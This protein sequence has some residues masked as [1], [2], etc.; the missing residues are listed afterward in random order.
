MVTCS[1]LLVYSISISQSV[2]GLKHLGE[3]AKVT[4]LCESLKQALNLG[5]PGNLTSVPVGLKDWLYV[6]E[7]LV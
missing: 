5:A 1:I 7:I 2:T 3:C 6:V 4:L